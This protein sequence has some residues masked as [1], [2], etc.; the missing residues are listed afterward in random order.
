MRR[1]G[2]GRPVRAADVVWLLGLSLAGCR[3][4]AFG[5]T[6]RRLYEALEGADFS[7]MTDADGVLVSSIRQ[8]SHI[9][10]NEKGVGAASFT[11]LAYAGAALPDGRAKMILDRPFLYG[12]EDNGVWL[13]IGVCDVPQESGRP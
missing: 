6:A 9:S 1:N 4:N 12:I 2:I 8:D 3:E 13:F 5:D 10:V 11:D 7:Q